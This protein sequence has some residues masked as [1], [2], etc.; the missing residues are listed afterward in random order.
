MAY[1]GSLRDVLKQDIFKGP[2]KTGL[3][4]LADLDSGF[5]FDKPEGYSGKVV[6]KKGSL[7]AVHQVYR[8]KPVVRARFEAHRLYIDLQ[9]VW[10]GREIITVAPR[11]GLKRISGYDREKDIEFFEYKKT[12]AFI[13]EP[14]TVAVLFPEDAH[15]PALSFKKRELIRKTVVKILTGGLYDE[16]R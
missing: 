5:L 11:G 14:G 2:L 6:L 9:Y 8:S 3:R 1:Y 15:A 7:F 10:E 16:G 4:F 12:S 13:M